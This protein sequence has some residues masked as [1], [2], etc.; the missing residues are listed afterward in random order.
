MG[1]YD[2][3]VQ[4]SY[5]ICTAEQ[6]IVYLILAMIYIVIEGYYIYSTVKMIKDNMNVLNSP[7]LCLFYFGVHILFIRSILCFFG[8]VLICYSNDFYFVMAMYFYIIKHLIVIIML[9]RIIHI[10]SYINNEVKCLRYTIIA[11]GIIDYCSFTGLFI[12]YYITE[13]SIPFNSYA[14]FSATC[15]LIIVNL[16]MYRFIKM[17]KQ[18]PMYMESGLQQWNLLLYSLSSLFIVRII[19]KIIGVVNASTHGAISF[20]GSFWYSIYMTVYYIFNEILPCLLIFYALT[21]AYKTKE[22]LM[23]SKSDSINNQ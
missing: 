18:I 9:Y 17:L 15:F 1:L 3:E 14:I 16:L 4:K 11:W 13:E 8:G 21:K 2:C 5:E 7:I 12:H 20:S 6:G 19:Y 10:L 23:N 22:S